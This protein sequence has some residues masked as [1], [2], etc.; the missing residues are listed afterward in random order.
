MKLKVHKKT[1]SKDCELY[2][3]RGKNDHVVTSLTDSGLN[4]Q[5]TNC[6]VTDGLRERVS[7]GGDGV[8]VL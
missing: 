6:V 2:A 7:E 5:G 4:V 8:F 3:H 1:R